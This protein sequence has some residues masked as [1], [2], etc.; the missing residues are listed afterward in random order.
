MRTFSTAVLAFFLSLLVGSAAAVKI[1]ELVRA[2]EEFILVF[3]FLP[4]VAI[5]ACIVFAVAR[6]RPAPLTN[7][8]RAGGWLM[9]ALVIFA[10]ALVAFS[11]YDARG[12][13]GV[14]RDMPILA[15]LIAPAFLVVATQWLFVRWRTAS[16]SPS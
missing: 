6:S 12:L 5:I 7:I 1:A 14:G 8:A 10:L 9:G 13:H 16:A 2:R 11:I 15:G 4:L 3:M